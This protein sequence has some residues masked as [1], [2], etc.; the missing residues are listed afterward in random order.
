MLLSN[1]A[2][3]QNGIQAFQRH[4]A[5][6]KVSDRLNMLISWFTQVHRGVAGE[7]FL[8]SHKPDNRI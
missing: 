1:I 8:K 6:S 7:T 4:G 2:K 5:F 3:L